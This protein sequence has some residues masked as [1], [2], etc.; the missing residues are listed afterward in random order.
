VFTALFI[1]LLIRW[2]YLEWR[3]SHLRR[4]ERGWHE[5]LQQLARDAG[6]QTPEKTR[7]MLEELAKVGL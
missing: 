6:S 7:S 1:V 2:G 5:A 4:I 3:N